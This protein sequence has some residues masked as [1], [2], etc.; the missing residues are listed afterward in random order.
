MQT[1]T[2][3]GSDVFAL[4]VWL[5]LRHDRRRPRA[6]KGSASH[7]GCST[8]N[9]QAS[10]LDVRLK[11]RERF[12]DILQLSAQTFTFSLYA[13]ELFPPV[14]YFSYVVFC[15]VGNI[16]SATRNSALRG[17]ARVA[18]AWTL[19]SLSLS[20]SRSR[21]IFSAVTTSQPIKR[22]RRCRTSTNLEL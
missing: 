22:M 18:V 6:S 2:N 21:C 15:S 5:R 8:I 14:S 13:R 12:T 7:D 16:S 10:A 9:A 11:S 3:L 4:A 19:I 20:S 1:R 17:S